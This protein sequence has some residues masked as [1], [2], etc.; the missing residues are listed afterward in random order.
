MK[1]NKHFK[2]VVIG[3]SLCLTMLCGGTMITHAVTPVCGGDHNFCK[4]RDAG[5]ISLGGAGSHSHNGYYCSREDKQDM[6]LERC[7]CGMERVVPDGG[8]YT[9]HHID[10]SMKY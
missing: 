1:G 8:V 3:F 4:V 6:I 9:V 2:G 7:Y 10:Y 5:S